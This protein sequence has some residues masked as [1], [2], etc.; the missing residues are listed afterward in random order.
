[1]LLKRRRC[2]HGAALAVRGLAAVADVA[3]RVHDRGRVGPWAVMGS[4]KADA[5]GAV[6][7]HNEARGVFLTPTWKFFCVVRS[8]GTTGLGPAEAIGKGEGPAFGMH[9]ILTG[10][11]RSAKDA[12]GKVNGRFE[13]V[14]M[15]WVVGDGSS[16]RGS[17]GRGGQ[18]NRCVLSIVWTGPRGGTGAASG[19]PP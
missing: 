14:L 6:S 18:C 16:P 2:G 19:L 8:W 7:V 4:A 15:F 3:A 5:M 13:G 1:M 10:H 9:G 11:G 12:Y 17:G